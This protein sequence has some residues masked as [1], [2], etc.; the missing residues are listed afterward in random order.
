MDGAD[1]AAGTVTLSH[2]P[3]ASLNWPAM[4]MDFAVANPALQAALKPGARVAV[5]FVERKPGEWVITAVRPAAG[6]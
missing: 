6:R 1:A 4:T 2:G 5:D 3:V